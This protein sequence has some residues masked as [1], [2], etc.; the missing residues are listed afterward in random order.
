M[1]EEHSDDAQVLLKFSDTLKDYQASVLGGYGEQDPFQIVQEFRSITGEVAMK[2]ADHGDNEMEKLENWEL[3]ANLWHLVELLMLFRTSERDDENVDLKDYNSNILFKKKLLE[4]N[5]NLYEIWLIKSWIQEN[6]VIPVRPSNLPSTKWM[7][8]VL[9]GGLKSS[10]I[11]YP[12]RDISINID[13]KDKED[14]HIFYKYIYQLMLAGKFK[15][16]RK[17][18][19]LSDNLTLNMIL[20]GLEDYVDPRVDVEMSSEYEIRHGIQKHTLWRRT[21]YLLSLNPRLDPYEAAIYKFLAGDIPDT[22]PT[23][24]H[25]WD[26][27]IS[28]YLN[29]IWNITIENYLWEHNRINNEEIITV[30]PSQP[31]NLSEVLTIVASKY[32]EKSK[33]PL[34]VLIGSIML[35]TVSSAIR[36]FIDMLLDLLKG[37]NN[38]TD[39]LSDKYLLRVITHLCIFSDIICPSII[40]KSDKKKLITAYVSLLSLYELHDIVPVYI[41]FL[42]EEDII[43][44]YSF[45]LSNLSNLQSREKQLRLSNYL[46]FPTANILRKTAQRIFNDTESYYNPGKTIQIFNEIANID[47]RLISGVEWLIEGKLYTDSIESIIALSRRFLLNGKVKSLEYFFK[48]HD[49]QNIIK[50]YELDKLSSNNF[51]SQDNLIIEIRQYEVLVS[52]FKKYGEWEKSASLFNSESNLPS[53]VKQFKDFSF[54]IHKIIKSFL[55]HFNETLDE[56]TKDILHEIRAL[57]IPYLII[58]LHK[59]LIMAAE[60]LKIQTFIQEAVNLSILVANENDKIYLLF[61]AT[62]RLEEY[63]QLVTKAMT[64]LSQ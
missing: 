30:M 31:L 58:E 2:Y 56:E 34:R 5:K 25:G 12:L 3:E 54:E 17:E 1:E 28:I 20:C 21:V 24:E 46:C 57:Y 47:K 63:L 10:D 43:D 55:S 41:S 33:H 7:N 36:S 53:L 23:L 11:D 37:N 6:M 64:L 27:E 32:P 8:T 38:E 4:E 13:P 52:G 15:D 39:L 51:N 48:C 29:Q 49:I 14:D 50:N 35:N 26:V 61:Q 40:D 59:S 16:V 45:F 42:D 22:L 19:E 9:A 62:D 18:C 60:S 44:G